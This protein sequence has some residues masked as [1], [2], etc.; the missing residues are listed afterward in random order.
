MNWYTADLHFGHENIIKYSFRP[1]KSSDDMEKKIIKN[2]ND[3][4]NPRHH[5]FI[6]GD[7][8]FYNTSDR[9]EGK[10]RKWFWYSDQLFG[11]KIFLQG[12]HDSRNHLKTGIINMVIKEAGMRIFLTHRPQDIIFDYDLYLVGHVHEKW[13]HRIYNDGQRN[14]VIVNVGVDMWNFKPVSINEILKYLRKENVSLS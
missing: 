12:N 9:G 7:F 2:F 11:N 8:S 3:R 14:H 10:K 13:K 4:I 6:I 5:L 1:F